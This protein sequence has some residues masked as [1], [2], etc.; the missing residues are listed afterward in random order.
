MSPKKSLESPGKIVGSG[1]CGFGI[2]RVDPKNPPNKPGIKKE[3]HFLGGNPSRSLYIL[4]GS[5]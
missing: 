5:L 1:L 4:N 2:P 3:A